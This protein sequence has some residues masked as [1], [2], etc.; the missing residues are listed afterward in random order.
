MLGSP[1]PL[2][3]HWIFRISWIPIVSSGFLPYLGYGNPIRI[4][5][6]Q[7]RYKAYKDLSFLLY[8]FERFETYQIDNQKFNYAIP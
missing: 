6:I 8:I 7:W 3:P 1:Y 5:N 2:Y 4:C